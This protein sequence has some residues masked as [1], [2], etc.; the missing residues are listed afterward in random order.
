MKRN[1]GR[2][3]FWIFRIMLLS[4]FA[5]SWML[6]A[7]QSSMEYTDAEVANF[8][9]DL[10]A[11]TYDTLILSTS[12]GIY[13]VSYPSI[14]QTTVIMGKEGLEFKPILKNT[15]NTSSS[16][17]ILSLNGSDV[18]DTITFI[19]LEFDG[20]GAATAPCIIRADDENHIVFRDC[21]IHNAINDNGAIRINNAGSSIDMQ[22][23][24]ITDSKQRMIA[25]Y[26]TGALYGDV[27]VTNCTFAGITA[28]N[29]IFFRSS[30]GI[31][32][33]GN[34]VTIDHCTFYNIGA[35]LLSYQDDSIHGTVSVTNSIFD[36]VTGEL[37][38]DVIDYNYVAGMVT[39]PAI[40]T[41]SIT[42][43][44]VFANAATMNF[45]LLN[46]DDLT[47][48]DFQILGDLSWY[49]DTYPPKVYADLIKIDP[50][51][52]LVKYNE[53]VDETTALVLANYSLSGTAGLSGNPSEV[54]PDA[55]G[56]DVTLTISD[57][58][59][60]VIGQTVIVTVT[61]VTDLSGNVI[62]NVNNTATYTLLDE[63][64]PAV[65]MAEQTVNN[66]EGKTATARS[67]E[68]GIIY[69]I[70]AAAAQDNIEDFI[71]AIESG[72]GSSADVITP[73]VDVLIPT[74]S[75]TIGNYYAYAVDTFNNISEKS[76]NAVIVIDTT[77]PEI[78]M[79]AQE[80]TNSKT[81][82]V[83]AQSNER[84]MIYLI[85]DGEAQSTVAEFE[86]AIAAK[87]GSSI[88]VLNPGEEV[89][90]SS[91]DLEPGTYYSYAV[92]EVGNISSKSINAVTVSKFVP[93]IRYYAA[94]D[95][96]QM[97]SDIQNAADGDVFVLTTS[98]GEY[99][100]LDR[101]NIG[102]KI[103][104]MAA[105]GL[106]KKPA[107]WNAK[108]AG[109]AQILLFNYPNLGLT[110]KGV[111]LRGNSDPNWPTSY[112]IRANNN[113]GHYYL[114]AEDC[115]FN[116]VNFKPQGAIFRNYI[117]SYG[118]SIIFRNCIFEGGEEA[119]SS[120]SDAPGFDKFEVTNCT[121]FNL[122]QEVINITYDRN[123]NGNAPIDFNH[124]TF[125]NT[126]GINNMIFDLDSN[127]HVTV[128]N[129]IIANTVAD[130]IWHMYG[131]ATDKSTMDYTNLFNCPSPLDDKGGVLGSN[132]FALDPMFADPSAGDFTLGNATML[133]MA[134]D[135]LPL[136][137]L[138][139]ADIFGPAVQ[140]A[141]TARSDS[142]LLLKYNEWIDTVSAETV[143][144]YALSGSAGYTGHVKK[145]EL[146][147]F[148]SVL[149]TVESFS[150]QVGN[151]IVITVSNVKDLKG[152][153]VDPAQNV[154]TY[155]VEEFR[156]VVTA[157]IQNVT[158]GAGQIVIA[159]SNQGS[160]FV[161]VIL[162]G[163]PQATITDLDAAVAALKGAKAAVTEAYTNTEIDVYGVNT[164]IYYAY[165][166][167]ASGNL[168]E[169][170]IY[171]ITITDGIPPVITAAIQSAD[172]SDD[173]NVIV[174]SNEPGKVYIVLDGEPQATENNF[175]S[176]IFADK[177]SSATVTT[178]NTDV[179]VPTKDL[180]PGIYY[181]Y[182][183]DIAGNISVKGTNPLNITEAPNSIE[184]FDKLQVKVYSVN[185][186]IVIES[187]S[188]EPQMVSI[189]DLVGR[190][191][192][193][194][195][196]ASD[197]HIFSIDRQG[198]Y[199]VK[200]TSDVNGKSGSYKLIVQ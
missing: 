148:Y 34:N 93:R 6:T 103:T 198:I 91:Q 21:Y 158:N 102:A 174:Q 105:E 30:G 132:M 187:A 51:H 60:M 163:E 135:G 116:F 97:E 17:A 184:Q 168:S 18:R 110:L 54:V 119:L 141:M 138:R 11:G 161:Y 165:A 85:L 137:D 134:S 177:A 41:N 157:N 3:N 191:V 142:T 94:E 143:T 179:E 136:G 106:E 182:A 109:T 66:D 74:V 170:G 140:D 107:I 2:I 175:I 149:L 20:S 178:T 124:C 155:T 63:T 127:K 129:S 121:F 32:A 118:D 104:I 120:T 69:L 87:K 77:A 153:T 73:D 96:L 145:A 139:W 16:S 86:T 195:K 122:S 176:A 46:K 58:S 101:I 200:I 71:D 26:T 49:D 131:D 13:D 39:P 90:I 183:V 197:L 56:K 15:G 152:N 125:Y 156:P 172:N 19:N 181:A 79:L 4:F 83:F 8:V 167:D 162:D 92:D 37:K 42:T 123:L 22:N 64:P 40:A 99:I 7:A 44:P 112:L 5:W 98:G 154:S 59:G 45:T 47:G 160:G 192:I 33:A 115:Y 36:Q 114:V 29:I 150:D 111:E 146:F 50:T 1:V 67:N 196:I 193:N 81:D 70:H 72:M 62:E 117:N 171:E 80:V 52:L 151:E 9:T 130:T 57:L 113:I 88:G 128:M 164:G 186:T 82:K 65:T 76:T 28:G 133:N 27:S 78:T 84:G 35:K 24:L 53:M 75:L 180:V 190:A 188:S 173:D 61:N 12:G 23:T 166:T 14:S 144:N 95:A 55:N 126:G 89:S 108:N 100:T 31:Y 169:K 147:N 10:A 48:S 38:A 189:Y 43:A 25:L 159:Q 185:G 68:A 199:F 194:Q